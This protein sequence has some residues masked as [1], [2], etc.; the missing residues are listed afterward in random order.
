[1]GREVSR[2]NHIIVLI[3]WIVVI[4]VATGY[5]GLETP[6]IKDVAIDKVY[7][8]VAFLLLGILELRILRTSMFFLVG[9]SVVILAELQ[10][11]II[12]GREFELLDIVAGLGGLL[13][14]FIYSKGRE[15]V[16]HGL[17]KT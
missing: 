4:F 12:P 7:H 16:K 13:A 10:Q 3:V 2:K 6:R 14:V 8:F 1:M 5:P 15:L 11:L 17:S 9:V